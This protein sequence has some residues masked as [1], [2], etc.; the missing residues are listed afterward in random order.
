MSYCRAGRGR[1]ALPVGRQESG[2]PPGGTAGVWRPSRREP[3]GMGGPPG[4]PGGFGRPFRRAGQ[5]RAKVDG[6][7]V[8]TRKFDRCSCG[9]TVS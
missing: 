6:N 7:P 1:E 2:G 4:V 3:D 5:C 9:R 8:D